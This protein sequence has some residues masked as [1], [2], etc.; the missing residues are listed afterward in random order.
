ML[1]KNCLVKALQNLSGKSIPAD[2]LANCQT[3]CEVLHAFNAL[4]SC[5]VTFSGVLGSTQVTNIMSVSVKDASGTIIPAGTGGKYALSEGSYTYSATCEGAVD[6]TDV[7]FEI[8]NA[9]E[10]KGTKSIIITF[11]AA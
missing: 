5:E 7:A 11:T 4:Y 1:T 2:V 10:Q 3:T 9:D 6:K 8:T